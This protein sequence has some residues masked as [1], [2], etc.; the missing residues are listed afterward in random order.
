MKRKKLSPPPPNPWE[1]TD[2]DSPWADASP[3][4]KKDKGTERWPSV[5]VDPG[6][7]WQLPKV[8]TKR[9]P[10]LGIEPQ[11]LLLLL[12]LQTDRYRNRP[13]RYYWEELA[14]DCGCTRN[15]VRRWGYE[16]RDKC[17]LGITPVPRRLE[18]E[19]R[20][21]GYRNAR[22]IFDLKPFEVLVASIHRE[23]VKERKPRKKPA[24]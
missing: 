7:W 5:C 13:P 11:H 24:A 22:N 14:R 19:E 15:T 18:G 1:S 17:L 4:P 16:L 6:E 12:V 8:L 3:S 20:K 23:W 2:D 9:F 10:K 21:I